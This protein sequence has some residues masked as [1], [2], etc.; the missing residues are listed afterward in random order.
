MVPIPTTREPIHV[1]HQQ[2]LIV[3]LDGPN[4]PFP[5]RPTFPE[6]AVSLRVRS[7]DGLLAIAEHVPGGVVL[8]RAESFSRPADLHRWRSCHPADWLTALCLSLNMASVSAALSWLA[9]WP[10]PIL[11]D[12]PVGVSMRHD[13]GALADHAPAIR[14]SCR[15]LPWFVPRLVAVKPI[16]AAA[17]IA[18]YASPQP[19]NS[20]KQLAARCRLSERHLHRLLLALGIP[21]SY[22]FLATSRVMRAYGEVVRRELSLSEIAHR[23]GFGSVKTLKSQWADVTGGGLE[24]AHSF[25]LSDAAVRAMAERALVF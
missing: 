5:S 19:P 13:V 11:L 7:V 25:P 6:Q 12:Q 2:P 16:V 1:T 15:L 14:E 17:L 8:V 23:F 9:E 4:A 3:A 20:L 21:S 18:P 22:M 10:L 24:R